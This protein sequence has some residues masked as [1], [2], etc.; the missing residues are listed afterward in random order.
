MSAAQPYAFF[1]LR[2][3]RWLRPLAADN[4]PAFENVFAAGGILAGADRAGEGSRQGIDL[5]TAYR[6]VEAALS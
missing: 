3:D 4:K 5:A 6:A 2:V 1:G